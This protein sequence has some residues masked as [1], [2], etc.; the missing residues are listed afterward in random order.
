MSTCRIYVASV[1]VVMVLAVVLQATVVVA[2]PAYVREARNA[3][4]DPDCP[5][6]TWETCCDLQRSM[7][8]K[9]AAA[10]AA[11]AAASAISSDNSS[12]GENSTDTAEGSS[13][14]NSTAD[15]RSGPYTLG[16]YGTFSATYGYC[17]LETDGGGWLVIFRREGKLDFHRNLAE[18]E[19]GFG[20]LEYGKSFWYGLKSLNHITSRD[21]W[22]LRVDLIRDGERVHALYTNI[23]IG[24]TSER[25]I[26][27]LGPYMDGKSTA[28]DSFRAFNGKMFLTKDQDSPTRCARQSGGGWWFDRDCGGARG[29]ILTSS[30]EHLSG[31]YSEDAGHT[32]TYKQTEV[33]IR[34]VNCS[35]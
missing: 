30:Y 1:V 6:L 2:A 32:L 5:L 20:D 21:V 17:D 33:K 13:T 11:A 3:T 10:A 9:A 31:W 24:D 23:S 28:S 16:H 7:I 25:Y 26:L 19:D 29:G 34:Q 14:T 15:Y 4:N 22:E 12:S 27:H 8:E 18:Y 35:I